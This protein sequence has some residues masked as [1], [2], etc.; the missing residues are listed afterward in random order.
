MLLRHAKADWPPWT[1]DYDRPLLAGRGRLASTLMG[2]YMAR[3]GLQ[4]D[5]VLV[6][7]ARRA[8]ET[9]E[10]ASA[11][12]DA[13]I[14]R[15]DEPRIYEAPISTLLDVVLGTAAEVRALLLVG[16][17]PGLHGL[18]LTL[19]GQA[20]GSGAALL[21]ERYPTGGLAVIDF[22]VDRWDRLRP[23]SG[24]LE[25]FQTPRTIVSPE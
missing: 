20:S 10:L 16:H 11:A 5:L 19:I 18:A 1:A 2:E 23:A 15:R 7:P 22:A 12:F 25:R 9:W 8:Q 6:S 17:N 13:Q 21:N 3:E 14:A 24:T 4:P